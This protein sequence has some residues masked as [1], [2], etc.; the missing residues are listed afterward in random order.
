MSEQSS[1]KKNI[2]IVVL[3]LL[4]LA[5]AGGNIFQFFNT[6]QVVVEREKEKLVVDSLTIRKN[7]LEAEY[8]AS[9][10]QLEQFKGE[11]QEMDSLLQEAYAKIEDQRK[12]IAR[13]IDQ[14]QDYQILQ[15][16][17]D[18]LK[19]TTEFYLQEIQRL[20][21]E[22]KQ[23]KYENTQL[24]VELDQTNT[25]NKDLKGKVDVA[26]KLRVN[27]MTLTGLSVTNGGKEK[28]T[29][30]AKKTERLRI[31]FNI[32]ENP[33]A[34]TGSHTVYIRIINPEGYVLADAGQS[35]KKFT[36]EKGEETPYSKSVTVNYDGG[37]ISKT[38][39]WDQDAFSAGSYKIEVY[40]DGY[41][42]GTDKLN[43][44]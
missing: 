8:N 34:Q 10:A 35:V 23:L 11:N 1:S 19:K 26:S 5:S 27:A 39:S 28:E 12:K 25:E 21:A 14:N 37:K 38:I 40:I 43:L 29:D 15:Q 22:N 32:D 6:R 18:D 33:L 42:A 41:F 2:L 16:R 3:S 44:Y 31:T 36:N 17:F 24:S 9:I 13:L 7:R 4:L 20:Q 30:K